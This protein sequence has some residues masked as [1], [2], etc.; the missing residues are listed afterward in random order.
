MFLL[1]GGFVDH[2]KAVAMRDGSCKLY[3]PLSC[4]HEEADTC[5]ILN[6]NDAKKVSERILIW[7]PD[8]DVGVLGIQHY[9]NIKI[10]LWLRTGV[11]EQVKIC[12]T[13]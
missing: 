4:N 3:E 12:S 5:F 2:E 1:R 11:K 7:S 6:A 13:T 8:T 9:K 10:E